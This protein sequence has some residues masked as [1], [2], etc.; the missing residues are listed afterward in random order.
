MTR[1]IALYARRSGSEDNTSIQKQIEA[2][3]REAERITGFTPAAYV[4]K[5][6]VDVGVSGATP[7]NERPEGRLLMR[8]ARRG[9]FDTVIFYSLDRFTR[10][11]AAGLADFETMEDEY[12]LT[13][14][15]AK[16]NIDTSTP[17]GKLFRTMLAAFAE[18]E[19]DTIRDRHMAGRHLAAKSGQGW[20]TGAPPYG[21][22]LNADGYLSIRE[23]E[24]EVVRTMF[25]MRSIGMTLREI[26]N[27]LNEHGIE[28]RR[29]YSKHTG[30]PIAQ[31][32]GSG[33]VH[34]YLKQTA[35]KGDPITRRISP[36]FGQ[37]A[38][39]FEYPVPAIISEALWK[40]AQE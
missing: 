40:K 37:P 27:H 23:D 12:G 1:R 29:R 17:S 6:Y 24:A 28:P 18:F 2:G 10:S 16:E 36:A 21:Y 34:A 15:F 22:L 7:F 39:V 25:E 11:T 3:Q 5:T 30:N 20:S 13:L 9:K 33:S 31:V 35:Y 8:D 32:F 14:V 38:E 26:A 19:R 4:A